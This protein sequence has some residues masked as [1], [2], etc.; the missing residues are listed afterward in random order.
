LY[1]VRIFGKIE[2]IDPFALGHHIH[3]QL[4]CPPPGAGMS[5]EDIVGQRDREPIA[6]LGQR[7]RWPSMTRSE[8]R[9]HEETAFG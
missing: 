2:S 7:C 1:Q 9:Q 8:R 3:T 6:L 4:L 5:D